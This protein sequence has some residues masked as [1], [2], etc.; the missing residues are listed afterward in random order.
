VGATKGFDV[1]SRGPTV[2]LASYYG[3]LLRVRTGTFQLDTIVW[4]PERDVSVSGSDPPVP[5]VAIAGDRSYWV[6]GHGVF[7]STDAMTWLNVTPTSWNAKVGP[8]AAT[9]VLPLTGTRG[10]VN[11]N[12]WVYAILNYQV[13][14]DPNELLV[15]LYNATS[16]SW[17]EHPFDIAQTYSPRY[18][19]ISATVVGSV[20]SLL[21]TNAPDPNS[22]GDVIS[23]QI[24]FAGSDFDFDH[25]GNWWV[26]VSE[27]GAYYPSIA[28]GPP[29]NLYAFWRARDQ[30]AWVVRNAT[31]D[32]Y[33]WKAPSTM[34]PVIPDQDPTWLTTPRLLHDKAIVVWRNAGGE[35]SDC[36][37]LFG[38]FPLLDDFG[39]STG[40]PGRGQA[41]QPAFPWWVRPS[42]SSTPRVACSTC[43]RRTQAP[44]DEEST[45]PSLAFMRIRSRSKARL[46]CFSRPIRPFQWGS[47]GR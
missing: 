42:I 24:G 45:W 14:P 30:D 19:K 3:T 43:A 2:A 1:D 5:S 34:F 20:V 29:G 25:T 4:G 21:Y 23:T 33:V 37:L 17:T 12:G 28:M 46:P 47:D 40:I 10:G 15:G 35:C 18:D 7:R 8:T 39:A 36:S 22:Y 41:S 32:G 16:G 44:P 6:A 38:S 9:F 26:A 11:L 27:L 31:H 13:W